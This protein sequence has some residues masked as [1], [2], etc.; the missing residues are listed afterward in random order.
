MGYVSCVAVAPLLPEAPRLHTTNHCL[1]TTNH[2]QS[3]KIYPSLL[4]LDEA[5]VSDCPSLASE[6]SSSPMSYTL[7]IWCD[8]VT[9]ALVAMSMNAE[10]GCDVAGGRE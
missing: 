1:H 4:G 10:R 2:C 6:V 5:A 7:P 8:V 9:E 3:Q